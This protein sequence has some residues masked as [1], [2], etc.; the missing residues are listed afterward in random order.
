MSMSLLLLFSKTTLPLPLRSIREPTRNIDLRREE[1]IPSLLRFDP[2][3]VALAL[4]AASGDSR[5]IAGDGGGRGSCAIVA[6]ASLY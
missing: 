1:K 5:A 4:S 6:V 3:L 2:D